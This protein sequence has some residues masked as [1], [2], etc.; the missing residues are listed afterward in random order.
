VK[1]LSSIINELK[2]AYI[3]KNL[4]G[5]VYSISL[6]LFLIIVLIIYFL[7]LPNTFIWM[8][9]T[10]IVASIAHFLLYS[11]IAFNIESKKERPFVNQ[12]NK[13]MEEYE[14]SNDPQALYN[15]LSNIRFLPVKLETKNAYNLS[16]STALY[17]INRSK[18]ALTYLDKIE[19]DNSNLIKIVEEQRKL[20]KG[21]K[22]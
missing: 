10:L 13:I 14:Q 8:L 1:K 3:N 5:S 22:K 21:K 12:Y 9:G 17:R 20:F 2:E 19:T 16:M 7:Y 18:E 4:T 11:F 15:G 6:I